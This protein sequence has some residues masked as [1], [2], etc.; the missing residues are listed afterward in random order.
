LFF[1]YFPVLHLPVLGLPTGKGS[2]LQTHRE[3]FFS[4]W[5]FFS[6]LSSQRAHLRT[7][8]TPLSSAGA[9]TNGDT[10]DYPFSQLEPQPA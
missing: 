3:L 6:R 9:P 4:R 8:P 2:H 10:L 5:R 7:A 1:P